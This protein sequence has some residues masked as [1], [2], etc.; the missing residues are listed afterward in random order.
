[1]Q[2]QLFKEPVYKNDHLILEEKYHRLRK[3][4]HARSSEK[5]KKIRELEERLSL[6]EANIC[7]GLIQFE[8][9]M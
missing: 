5:D 8:Q 9:A 2:L 4:L 6:L 7:K 3:S 1:M